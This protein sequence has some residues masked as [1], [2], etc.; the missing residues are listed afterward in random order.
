VIHIRFIEKSP[1]LPL[2]QQS[3]PAKDACG[4]MVKESSSKFAKYSIAASAPFS[5]ILKLGKLIVPEVDIVTL[6]LEEFS[7]AEMR[8]LEPFQAT[9]SLEQKSFSS[10]GFY[11]AYSV[12]GKVHQWDS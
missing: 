8:W 10:G 5:Q 4:S 7:L 1:S 2:Q 11:N 6:S 12:P 3:E 9:F